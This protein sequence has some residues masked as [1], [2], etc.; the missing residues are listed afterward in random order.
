MGQT[1]HSAE[2]KKSFRLSVGSGVAIKNNIRKNNL[3][4]GD[5][6]D[7]LINPLP[8][9]QFA[10]GP[11]FIGQQGLTISLLGDREKSFYININN[12]GDRY[13]GEGMQ[14]RRTSFFAG[15]GLKYHKYSFHLARDINGRSHGFKSSLSYAEMYTI[16]KTFFTRSSMTL[17]C[18]DHRYS[19]Y[20]YGV[21][22]F[23]AS[24]ILPEY[25]P[26]AYCSLGM[27]FFPGYKFSDDLSAVTGLSLKNVPN[28]VRHSPT[29]NDYWLEMALILGGLWQ[30]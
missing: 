16:N 10:W 14:S 28:V 8:F 7:V 6:G 11:V 23:E 1:L 22:N 20:Y 30:F 5:G 2:T 24:A 3:H 15:G 18:F 21:R 19:E 12:G 9:V 26:G 25:H 13:D 29:T 4:S 27:S 17:D